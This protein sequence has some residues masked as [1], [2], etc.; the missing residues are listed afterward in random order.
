MKKLRNKIIKLALSTC[1]TTSV[2]FPVLISCKNK[3][4]KIEKISL[5]LPKNNIRP[6]ESLQVKAI[7]E[8]SHTRTNDLNW[9][10]IDA[11]EGVIISKKGVIFVPNSLVM[12]D[13]KNITVVA[14]CKD[15]SNVKAQID[16]SIL[17]KPTLDFQ[18]F[19]NNEIQ[20]LDRAQNVQSMQIIQTSEF[21]YETEKSIDLF[22]GDVRESAPDYFTSFFYFQPIVSTVTKNYMAFSMDGSSHERHGIIW[23]GG[24]ADYAWTSKIPDIII[25]DSSCPMDSIS[26]NFSCDPRVSFKIKLNIWQGKTQDN[27]GNIWY[28][29]DT[30]DD[31]HDL[32]MLAQGNYNMNI[33][34]PADSIEGTY[35]GHIGTLYTCRQ[36]REYTEFDIHE[37]EYEVQDPDIRASLTVTISEPEIYVRPYDHM[38]I[39]KFDVDYI[40]DLAKKKYPA[41]HW[42]YQSF[43]LGTINITDPFFPSSRVCW[44]ELYIDWI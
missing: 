36:R 39:Y 5:Y 33:F 24:Y 17:P 12:D 14:A 8:P 40:F 2:F 44:L 27:A 37:F 15:D 6:G 21:T 38:N 25:N 20:Y 42:N 19:V 26:V 13:M 32:E 22:V 28:I 9:S 29:P 16:V 34:C 43:L 3:D 35:T 11:P 7:A 30:T 18:G 1:L 23:D 4:E 31:P 41:S 10:L